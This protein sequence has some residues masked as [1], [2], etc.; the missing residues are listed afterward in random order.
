MTREVWE[1][2]FRTI[3][4]TETEG[5]SVA[6]SVAGQEI[7]THNNTTAPTQHEAFHRI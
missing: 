3:S 2:L 4:L 5:T 7:I 6:R 1:F